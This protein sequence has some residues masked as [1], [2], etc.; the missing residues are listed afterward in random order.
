MGRASTFDFTG[1]YVKNLIHDLPLARPQ[2][3]A[4]LFGTTCGHADAQV[5][6]PV[7][8]QLDLATWNLTLSAAWRYISPTALDFNTNQ[9]A[10]KGSIFD[11]KP[12]DQRIPAFSC[13]TWR[14]STSC[15]TATAFRGGV[16]NVFDRTP[17]RLD[18]TNFGI[19]AP[20]FG[21]AN[22]YP[23]VFDPL[24]RTFF[25]GLTA[26]YKAVFDGP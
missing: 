13:S 15:T 5:A 25:I 14:S 26:D 7:P 19:S 6:S 8:H 18:T 9:P 17:P 12:T 21:N 2:D 22:T 4:G 3:C 16:N 1:T 20:P 11:R 23:Q 10:L 24:G